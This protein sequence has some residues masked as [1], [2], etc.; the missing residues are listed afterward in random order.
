MD[1]RMENENELGLYRDFA[2]MILVKFAR[3][4][5]YLQLSSNYP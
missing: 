4:F 5:N 1:K 3:K 2:G